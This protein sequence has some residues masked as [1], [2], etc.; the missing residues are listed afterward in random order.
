[1][2]PQQGEVSLLTLFADVHYYI[3]PPTQNPPH[4]RF[5]KSSYVYLYHNPMRQSGRIEI[6]NHAGTPNQDAFAGQLDTVKIEQT[7]KH[8]CLFTLTVDAFQSHNGTATPH[9]DMS[10]WHLP[11]PDP[12]N[13]GKY[14]Y[15]LH[16][17]DMYFWTPEDASLFLDSIR[18][19]LQ[20]HQLQIT[21][22]PNA[23]P[24][25]SEHKNDTFSPVIARLENAAISHTSRSPSIST[26]QSFP[27]P[28]SVPPPT[29]PPASEQPP[30]YA[31]M[32]Y[33]PAAPA[34]PEP[35][36]H[37]EKTPPPEDASDGTGLGA[38]AVHDQHAAQYSNPLQASF[39]PQ[40]TSGAYFP[41]P[42]APGQG[43]TG[44][45]GVQRTNTAGSV[46]SAPQSPPSFAPPPSAPPLGQ[47]N[48]TPPPP[49]LSRT[50]TMPVQQYASANYPSSPGFPPAPQSPPAHSAVPSPGF[51]PQQ[52][53]PMASPSYSQFQYGSTAAQATQAQNIHQQVYR[54]T[55]NEAAVHHHSNPN[56]PQR[57]SNIGK[58]VD[59]VEKGIGSFLKKLDKKF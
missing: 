30:N 10:Q 52:Y 33:N 11:T 47:V 49:A 39:A 22:N 17:V 21:R 57:N 43:F 15:K 7:Y 55:E 4:H 42:P 16:T 32:A 41:G 28:P 40:P 25:H 2:P 18:R 50:S 34:A 48:N 3:S 31:P 12:S 1:M 37:R 58:R 20:P 29:S 8:P 13:Q 45:P 56:A 36:A 23:T 59:K 44:P 14:M 35:I 6:A 38:S 9:Q 27:G 24:T 19:V 51:P 53:Q 54:P 26:T 5:D 46:P